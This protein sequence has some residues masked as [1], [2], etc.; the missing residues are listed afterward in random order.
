M[1]KQSRRRN[2]YKELAKVKGWSRED[3]PLSYPEVEPE[4]E[5]E[6]EPEPRFREGHIYRITTEEEQLKYR[7]NN[8][9]VFRF[10]YQEG[11]HYVFREIR[12]GWTRTYTDAQLIGKQIRE[13][14]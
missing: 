3:R 8:E 1:S 9:C 2:A 11:I 6:S 5:F 12:G 13:V 4:P 10:E 14:H 7:W